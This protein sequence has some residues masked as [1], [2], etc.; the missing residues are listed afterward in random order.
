MILLHIHRGPVMDISATGTE[1]WWDKPW[2]TGFRKHEVAGP[3]HI[4]ASGVDG[5]EQ[6]DL[7]NHGGPDKALCV[8]PAEHYD[9]WHQA[10][11]PSTMRHGAFGEN[12]TTQG[13]TESTVFIGDV[14][15][16]PDGT[17]VQISQP[18]QPCWK[19]ARR[20]RIK[21]LALQVER[22]GRTGWYF[23]VLKAG[24]IAAG[25]TLQLKHRPHPE[26]SVSLANELMH[27]RKEDLTAASA[28]AACEALSA[29]WRK[30]FNAR[31]ERRES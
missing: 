22:T 8:Y 7:E 24:V 12:F 6:A 15:R 9:Q 2:R 21:D 31:L 27:H 19:L 5:D 10:L 14:F 4:G 18:R 25:Q 3:V 28:L 17:E 13:M 29:S 1:A 26:W 30:V 23:R 20:W 16:F 11:A